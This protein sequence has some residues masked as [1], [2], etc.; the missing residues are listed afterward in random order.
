[1][2]ALNVVLT[3]FCQMLPSRLDFAMCISLLKLHPLLRFFSGVTQLYRKYV[4]NMYNNS[5]SLNRFKSSNLAE[6]Q[7]L[8][9]CFFAQV[10]ELLLEAGIPKQ[11]WIGGRISKKFHPSWHPVHNCKANVPHES[12]RSLLPACHSHNNLK[13]II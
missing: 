7:Q 2:T 13:Q 11:A 3:R 4:S 10:V 6:G 5:N 12:N 9:N 1:M 8:T